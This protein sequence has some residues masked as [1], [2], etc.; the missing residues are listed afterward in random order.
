MNFMSPETR[1]IVL[2]DSGYSM[3]VASFFWTKRRNVTEGQTDGQ[4]DRQT[5]RNGAAIN[6]GKIKITEIKIHG[7]T[8]RIE[9]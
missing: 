9:Q 1:V 3:I 4:T 8:I 7:V 2:L 6:T 5:D